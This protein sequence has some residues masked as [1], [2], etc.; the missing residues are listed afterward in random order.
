V[1]LDLVRPYAVVEGGETEARVGGEDG[2]E[3]GG[4]EEGEDAR[5]QVLRQRGERGGGGGEVLDA[6][7]EGGVDAL[8]RGD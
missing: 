5:P 7:E 6:V 8:G 1:C 3:R 2:R 4:G